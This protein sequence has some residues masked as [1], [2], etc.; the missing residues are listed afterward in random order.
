MEYNYI[1]N[2]AQTPPIQRFKTQAIPC[3]HSAISA[4]PYTFC[5][6]KP[7]TI[8]HSHTFGLETN[9]DEH[10]GNVQIILMLNYS[11]LC[12]TSCMKSETL[13]AYSS[14]LGEQSALPEGSVLPQR[15]KMC[16]VEAKPPVPFGN[17]G[18]T[19]LDCQVP[20]AAVLY[21]FARKKKNKK[22][23]SQERSGSCH[24]TR[25]SCGREVCCSNC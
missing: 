15:R 7:H 19:A 23:L 11:S 17:I 14:A 13:R 3:S 2:P 24:F 22:K 18:F 10:A 20:A 9:M 4:A 12:A 21:E 5:A 6:R 1:Y 25:P 8:R 16:I